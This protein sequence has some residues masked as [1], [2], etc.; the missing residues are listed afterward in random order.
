MNS[1][2]ISWKKLS[3]GCAAFWNCRLITVKFENLLNIKLWKVRKV[4]SISNYNLVYFADHATGEMFTLFT[5]KSVEV[6]IFVAWF[7]V[8]IRLIHLHGKPFK[9]Q[10]LKTKL[11]WHMNSVPCGFNHYNIDPHLKCSKDFRQIFLHSQR[12]YLVSQRKIYFQNKTYDCLERTDVFKQWASLNLF[13][14]LPVTLRHV[15]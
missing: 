1:Q 4:C 11:S 10:I 14:C 7:R 9:Q 12:S 3:F 13:L 2:A 5:A 8:G 6:V 15:K